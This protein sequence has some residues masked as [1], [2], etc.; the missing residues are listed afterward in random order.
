MSR[1]LSRGLQITLD[2]L[3]LSC[4]FWLAFLFRFEFAIPGA[5]LR[6][7][8]LSW[9]YAVILQ[10]GVLIL[11]G[12]PEL[13]WRYLGLHET[14]RIGLAAATSGLIMVIGRLTIAE[15]DDS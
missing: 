11:F 12:I 4:A 2:C 14:R 6:I 7:A 9:L 10:Y 1:L 3:V 13:S 5:Y 15:I 8:L